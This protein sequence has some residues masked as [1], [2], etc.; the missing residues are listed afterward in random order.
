MKLSMGSIALLGPG[1]IT[2]GAGPLAS[3]EGGGYTFV[4]S[5]AAALV[6]RF[7]TPPDNPRKLLIDNLVG[8]LKSDGVWAR[9]EL[10]YVLA[11]ADAQAARR[12]WIADVGN[13]AAVA[14]PIFTADRGYVSDGSS[15]YLESSY[16]LSTATLFTQNDASLGQWNNT[17]VAATVDIMAV[18]NARIRPYAGTGSVAFRPN[19]SATLLPA[20][21]PTTGSLA[22]SRTASNAWSAYGG[23]SLI[24]S[25]ADVSSA[26]S[27]T[28]RLLAI[29]GGTPS[30]SRMA[31]AWAGA[32]LS[33]AQ[34]AAMNAAL[35]TY[36]QAVGG[37]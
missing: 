22:Y 2:L 11:A 12:N 3:G 33:D 34:Q 6:A 24:S 36:L 27:G 31:A 18:G 5:E 7:T 15:A 4:N 10:F 17:L 29:S 37:A 13:L 19:T 16:E 35:N 25:A 28:L 9:L 26:V 1:Q 32:S 23:G 30:T 20:R 8:S 21:T 14:S